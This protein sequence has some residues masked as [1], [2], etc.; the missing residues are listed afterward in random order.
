MKM[1]VKE[2][3]RKGYNNA[4]EKI[5]DTLEEINWFLNNEESKDINAFFKGI[6]SPLLIYNNLYGI[7]SDKDNIVKSEKNKSILNKIL[8]NIIV[9]GS[10]LTFTAGINIAI[11]KNN[12]D[13]DNTLEVGNNISYEKLN[14]ASH[15]LKNKYFDTFI[16]FTTPLGNVIQNYFSNDVFVIPSE[17]S[18]LEKNLYTTSDPFKKTINGFTLDENFDDKTFYFGTHNTNNIGISH[19]F[20]VKIILSD[21]EIKR[22]LEKAV[23]KLNYAYN[24]KRQDMSRQKDRYRHQGR[25]N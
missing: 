19:L 6:I 4:L 11:E 13:E 2:K 9:T 21:D 12:R 3:I 25:T 24:S 5:D 1:K 20:D 22:G 10:I 15:R 16:R 7:V 18:D 14:N 8:N 17:L 23:E